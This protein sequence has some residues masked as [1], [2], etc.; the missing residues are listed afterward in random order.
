MSCFIAFCLSNK[1]KSTVSTLKSRMDTWCN[2]VVVYSLFINWHYI[3]AYSPPDNRHY[4][5]TH[6]FSGTCV[7]RVPLSL[8]IICGTYPVKGHSESNL[9]TGNINRRN[10]VTMV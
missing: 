9:L 7:A 1:R 10:F 5:T 3:V 2:F 4:M 8:S 6:I